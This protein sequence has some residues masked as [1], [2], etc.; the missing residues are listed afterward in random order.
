MEFKFDDDANMTLKT[1]PTRDFTTL[2]PAEFSR[3]QVWCSSGMAKQ[4]GGSVEF[5][6]Y[7]AI[8]AKIIAEMSRRANDQAN[9]LLRRQ[10]DLAEKRELTAAKE[11]ESAKIIEK[12]LFAFACV[13][14]IAASAQAFIAF[15]QYEVSQK[16]HPETTINVKCDASRAQRLQ[17]GY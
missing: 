2:S 5:Q 4:T 15:K 8:Q 11:L 17:A 7:E 12:G 13:S 1:V 9:E 3:L 6:R 14:A 10:L 16:P